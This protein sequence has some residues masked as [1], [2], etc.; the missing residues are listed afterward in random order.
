MQHVDIS[1]LRKP[2]SVSASANCLLCS[3]S[4][5]RLVR[6]P[7]N[8]C[9]ELLKNQRHLSQRFKHDSTATKIDTYVRFPATLNMAPYTTM[10]SGTDPCVVHIPTHL[11][12]LNACSFSDPARLGPSALY[13]YELFA[14]VIHEG[15]VNSGHY[16]NFARFGDH[17]STTAFKA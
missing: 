9:E 1:L 7:P 6:T 12:L 13:E 4:R 15:Q 8:T 14:V 5:S 3:P 10:A 17:V 16:T 11:S 2:R